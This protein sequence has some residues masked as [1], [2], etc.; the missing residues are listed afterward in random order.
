[1]N[2][3]VS[4]QDTLAHRNALLEKF[5][6]M[7]Q[8]QAASGTASL[9][10]GEADAWWLDERTKRFIE[11]TL[12]LSGTL[13]FTV[14]EGA[15]LHLTREQARS[16]CPEICVDGMPNQLPGLAAERSGC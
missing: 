10:E 9:V 8:Q 6:A 14:R 11:A 5:L 7:Q 16:M 15:P 12:N 1:M 4:E 3:S 13:T 2:Q